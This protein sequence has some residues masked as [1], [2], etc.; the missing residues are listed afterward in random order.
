MVE[1]GLGSDAKIRVT[2]E[3][4]EGSTLA[5]TE[6]Q[7]KFYVGVRSVT[8]HKTQAIKVDDNAYVCVVHT[9]EVGRGVIYGQLMVDIPDGDIP[10]GTRT[11]VSPPFVCGVKVV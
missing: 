7:C 1:V 8:I 9:A 10:D 5:N 11:E 3:E 2:M 6:W 4:I